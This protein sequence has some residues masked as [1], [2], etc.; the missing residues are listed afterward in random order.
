M[1]KEGSMKILKSYWGERELFIDG[2]IKIH[3]DRFTYDNLD[4][5]DYPKINGLYCKDHGEFS[6]NIRTHVIG[7]GGCKKCQ[8]KLLSDLQL[9]TNVGEI[10][11]TGQKILSSHKQSK[12]V[13]I[14][15]TIHKFCY[16]RFRSNLK[17]YLCPLC[18]RENERKSKA[19]IN[20]EIL[21]K[22][23]K[24]YES[25]EISSNEPSNLIF[26]CHKHNYKEI[27]KPKEMYCFKKRRDKCKECQKEAKRDRLQLGGGSFEDMSR[28]VYG[29]QFKY[30][31]VDYVNSLTP[32]TL[33]CKDHGKF[34]T[35][36]S[37]HLRGVFGGCKSCMV[38]SNRMVVWK[39]IKKALRGDY[40]GRDTT[41][42]IIRVESKQHDESF[43]KIGLSSV[44]VRKRYS[45]KKYTDLISYNI[46]SETVMT[47]FRAVL[48]ESYFLEVF[49]DHKITP[50]TKFHGYTECF[51]DYTLPMKKAF[52]R[53]SND[54]RL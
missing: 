21:S 7:S 41:F 5:K 22:E 10:S 8:Y 53:Y 17:D 49:R 3:K 14:E 23:L 32:V 15:C 54:R 43:I 26:C 31:E 50:R 16:E 28:K 34:E 33:I 19:K 36:P 13:R 52:E 25:L 40:A 51:E 48:L 46:I 20:L 9:Q 27:I 2:S 45:G 47:E 1:E 11:P 44:G 18:Q 42:Y 29:G 37:N 4:L 12:N 24:T 38:E 39:N 35:Y 6:C 30:E